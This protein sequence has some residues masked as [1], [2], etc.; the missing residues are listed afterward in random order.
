MEITPNPR[1]R[2]AMKLVV[3]L[4]VASPVCCYILFSGISF[5][6]PFST[7]ADEE[8]AVV[9]EQRAINNTRPEDTTAVVRSNWKVIN[10]T[11]SENTTAVLRKNRILCPLV[12]GLGHQKSGTTTIVKALGSVAGLEA[13]NDVQEFWEKKPLTD[14][15]VLEAL[16]G[17]P[18]IQKEGAG[19][20]YT[21]QMA[22]LCPQSSFYVVRRN[23]LSV[24]RSVADRLNLTAASD[25]SK[26]LEQVHVLWRPM[27]LHSND[28]SC[29]IRIA[30]NYV[31][32]Y[33]RVDELASKHDLKG[34]HYE[35]YLRDPLTSIQRLCNSLGNLGACNVT[36][37][38]TNQYQ[39]KGKNRGK[40]LTDIWP[41][42]VVDRLK[43]M[44]TSFSP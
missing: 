24:V 38:D 43:R 6:I 42:D 8:L 18:P 1:R 5:S 23:M 29:L 12:F 32:Y 19:L 13:R 11:R 15:Q 16:G 3:V 9:K 20:L 2:R 44:E 35:D 10:S 17:T 27:F 31:R 41:V 28:S 7:T 33:R 25:C 40:N 14:L 30:V 36:T 26:N 37:V 4:A 39:S 34:I 21:N 22:R